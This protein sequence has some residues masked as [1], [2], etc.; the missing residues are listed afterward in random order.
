MLS[1]FA[2][3]TEPLA[4]EAAAAS[5]AARSTAAITRAF[6][7]PPEGAGAPAGC[8]GRLKWFSPPATA[9]RLA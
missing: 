6:I 2:D 3:L 4:V 5:A 7:S 1:A 8:N 9:R